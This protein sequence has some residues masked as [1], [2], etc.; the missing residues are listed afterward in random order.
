MIRN[1]SKRFFLVICAKI[2][3]GDLKSTPEQIISMVGPAGFE[4]ATSAV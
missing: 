3:I 4:P 1:T 2:T